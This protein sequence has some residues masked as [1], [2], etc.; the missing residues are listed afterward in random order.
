M[1]DVIIPV[2]YSQV[3]ILV[4]KCM[5]ALQEKTNI[6]LRFIISGMGGSYDDWEPIR[7]MLDSMRDER[8]M[9]YGLL[10][11]DTTSR[12]EWDAV[13]GVLDLIKH[14][15]VLVIH[16][17]IQITDKNWFNKLHAPIRLAPYVGG[18]WITDEPLNSSTLEPNPILD[19][20]KALQGKA[21]L[22]TRP[23]IEMC[24]PF[25]KYSSF[26]ETFQD[27]ILKN[28]ATR[29]VAPGVTYTVVG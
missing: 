25:R 16:P 27:G 13:T 7:N 21:Y 6:P 19:T 26:S 14:N 12:T 3:P 28:G 15:F 1:I 10:S 4:G 8:E 23:H 2:Q 9:H 11:H 20:N 5:P 29:W 22:T 24:R 17:E 18:V